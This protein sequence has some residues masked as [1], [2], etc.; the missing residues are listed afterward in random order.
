APCVL[1]QAQHEDV[2][3]AAKIPP[4]PGPV[5]GRTTALRRTARP[6]WAR[7]PGRRPAMTPA[8]GEPWYW[9]IAAILAVFAASAVLTGVVLERLRRHAVLDRPGPRSAHAVPTPRGG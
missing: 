4:R 8:L 5:E 1:R 2:L 6:R 9:L 7:R 3:Y